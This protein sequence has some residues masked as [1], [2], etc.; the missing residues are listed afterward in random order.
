M[1]CPAYA[2]ATTQEN[3]ICICSTAPEAHE[4][5][6]IRGLRAMDRRLI[7]TPEGLALASKKNR[8]TEK[9]LVI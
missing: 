5:K 7:T 3:I 8:R 1:R 2:Y 6:A 4:L 9:Q